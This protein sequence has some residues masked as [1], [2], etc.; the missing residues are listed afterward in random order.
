[1]RRKCHP[2]RGELREC[3]V[4][5]RSWRTKFPGSTARSRGRP[6]LSRGISSSS[7][8]AANRSMRFL[9]PTTMSDARITKLQV[10]FWVSSLFAQAPRSAHLQ[11]R[12][13]QIACDFGPGPSRRLST[14]RPMCPGLLRRCLLVPA[15][16]EM[17]LVRFPATQSTLALSRTF[18]GSQVRESR[19]VFGAQIVPLRDCCGDRCK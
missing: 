11:R 7:F 5:Q 17:N 1:M 8:E 19:S 6:P 14:Q 9:F 2:E 16:L 13:L 3:G 18:A 10:S 4:S 15:A 12:R